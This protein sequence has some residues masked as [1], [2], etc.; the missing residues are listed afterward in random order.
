[1]FY[2]HPVNLCTEI[3]KSYAVKIKELLKMYSLHSNFLVAFRKE[4]V[5]KLKTGCQNETR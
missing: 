5:G 2:G 3:F 4:P 1:M